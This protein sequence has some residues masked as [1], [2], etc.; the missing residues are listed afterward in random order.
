MSLYHQNLDFLKDNLPTT[1][2]IF[3]SDE[4]K[5]ESKITPFDGS[6]LIVENGQRICMLHSAY[7]LE[8]E[9]A[10]MFSSI[11][12]DVECIV[13]F[14]MGLWY[15]RNHIF[16]TY[17]NLRHLIIVEP[18][19]NLF[20][21]VLHRIDLPDLTASSTEISLIINRS[22]TEAILSIWSFLGARDNFKMDFAYNLSYR[23]LYPGYFESVYQGVTDQFR[24]LWVNYRT[25]DS[26]MALWTYNTM[27]NHKYNAVPI[28]QFLGRFEDIPA[29]IV[30]AG[31]SLNDNMHYLKEVKDRAVIMAVG[32]AIKVLD[33]NGIVPHFRLAIDGTESE[34]RVFDG[35][36]TDNSILIF[37]DTLCSGILENYEGGKARM[38]FDI[39]A[40]DKYVFHRLYGELS[41]VQSGFSIANVALDLAIKLG[42]RKIIFM[43]QDLSY[44]EGK[45]YAKGIQPA[46][47]IDFSREEFVKTTNTAGETVYT[48]SFLLGMRSL[49]ERMIQFNPCIDYINATMRG[50]NIAGA[51]NKPFEQVMK[52]DLREN[53]HV[54]NRIDDLMLQ[55]QIEDSVWKQKLEKLNLEEAIQEADSINEYTVKKLRRLQKQFARGTEINKL[56]RD[57]NEIETYGEKQFES[58]EFYQVAVDSALK[59]RFQALRHTYQNKGAN[60]KETFE[61]NF[62]LALRKAAEIKSYL[63]FLTDTI[64]QLEE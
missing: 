36:Q 7:S 50:L 4:A 18:D 43:G 30:S 10:E 37:T 42:C 15:S 35:I 20:K 38:A 29:I 23:S 54:D 1:Y 14:G 34:R 16:N 12:E 26:Q 31:P 51:V 6:N 61:N 17:K 9:T 19:L 46:R 21:E 57:L 59:V 28:T 5:F 44:T 32:S 53:R 3:I 40:L 56:N 33:S 48:S 58:L 52:E 45:T 60:E 2:E 64:S 47:E 8:R 22:E 13:V 27:R 39:G 24:N 41:P 63:D 49:F 25:M 62:E 11:D 55:N